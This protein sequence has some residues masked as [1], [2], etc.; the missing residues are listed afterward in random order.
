MILPEFAT[1]LGCADRDVLPRLRVL[2]LTEP[3]SR[4]KGTGWS[5]EFERIACFKCQGH[6]DQLPKLTLRL[7]RDVA[8]R[9]V[10]GELNAYFAE[11]RR[12]RAVAR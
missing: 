2:K 11:R 9:I 5:D 6:A 3:C 4:C 10:R 1:A 12:Q 7:C 8:H